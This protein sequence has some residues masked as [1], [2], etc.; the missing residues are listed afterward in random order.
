[1]AL[2]DLPVLVRFRDPSDPASVEIVNPTN[3]AAAFG[4]GVVLKHAVIEITDDPVTKA[5]ETRLPWLAS[6]KES[7]RL[8]PPRNPSEGP[9]ALSEVPL[10]ERLSYN[11]FRRLPQ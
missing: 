3:L 1:V 5:I 2:E 7:P 11:D 4:P 8:F 10:V 9:R 6:S